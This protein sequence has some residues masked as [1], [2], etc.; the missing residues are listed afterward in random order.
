VIVG[1][2]IQNAQR[3]A[4]LVGIDIGDFVRHKVRSRLGFPLQRLKVTLEFL[5]HGVEEYA[6]PGSE[7]SGGT[8]KQSRKLQGF[9]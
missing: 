4:D 2:G 3:R 9:H 1:L 5:I 6:I 8:G 7:G